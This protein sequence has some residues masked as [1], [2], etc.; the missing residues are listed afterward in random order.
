[1]A[2]STSCWL[3]MLEVAHRHA[4]VDVLPQPPQHLGGALVEAGVVHPRL[5]A[6][7]DLRH[8]DVLGHGRVGAQR[9][10]LVHQADAQAHRVRRAVDHDLLAV[11]QDLALVG[12]VDAVD[13]VHQ[14]RLPRAVLAAQRVDLARVQREVHARERARSAEALADAAQFEQ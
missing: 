12:P 7:V 8:E 2:I 13:D 6:G 1:L 5:L 4:G 3:E 14:R 11:Q 10:L 9:D